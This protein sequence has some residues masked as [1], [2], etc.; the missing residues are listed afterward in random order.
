[1]LINQKT[2]HGEQLPTPDGARE[3]QGRGYSSRKMNHG[4]VH[5]ASVIIAMIAASAMVLSTGIV[6]A[7]NHWSGARDT[8]AP[9][10]TIIGV[11]ETA[12]KPFTVTFIF[13]ERV[14]G[15]DR[16]AISATNAKLSEFSGRGK[17]YKV[18]VK[19][20]GKGNIQI[21]V[22]AHSA[23]DMAGNTGPIS[24]VFSKVSAIAKGP[25]R[26]STTSTR[27]QQQRRNREN[28]NRDQEIRNSV[29]DQRQTAEDNS[30][31]GSADLL[32][33]PRRITQE[34]ESH[35]DLDD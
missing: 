18:N 2:E 30:Q 25:V 6:N 7:G 3:Q 5:R 8:D 19:P 12:D 1:M 27:A 26:T 16:S 23:E 13:S 21:I 20:S 9:A 31:L 29:N 11:P 32:A 35:V 17:S 4:F 34:D 15:F 14:T 10:L 28:R 33:E 24:E 22:T